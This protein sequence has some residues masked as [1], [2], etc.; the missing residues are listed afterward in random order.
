MAFDP[1]VCGI[2]LIIV[3]NEREF[4]ELQVQIVGQKIVFKVMVD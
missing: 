1:N 2:Y 4:Y 3:P